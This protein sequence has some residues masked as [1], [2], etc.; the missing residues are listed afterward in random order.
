M[1]QSCCI[2][3]VALSTTNDYF[4]HQSK[5]GLINKYKA[6]LSIRFSYKTKKATVMW[7]FVIFSIKMVSIAISGSQEWLNIAV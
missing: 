5:I 7:L 1:P 3:V 4:L 6:Y 2:C